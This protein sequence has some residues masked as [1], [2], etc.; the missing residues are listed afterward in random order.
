MRTF[1]FAI[2]GFTLL[3]GS[4]TDLTAQKNSAIYIL[5]VVKEELSSEPLTDVYVYALVKNDTLVI[6]TTV[7]DGKVDIILEYGKVY[8]LWYKKE[9]YASKA[10]RVD[11]RSIPKHLQDEEG[12]GLDIDIS[13]PT[14]IEGLDY[15]LL[16]EP[17][18][19]ANYSI[20][21]ENFSFDNDY[22]RKKLK[23]YLRLKNKMADFRK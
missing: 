15:S 21:D 9:G 2:L 8:D 6:D 18:G 1:F 12:Y 4:S 7:S 20:E 17:I 3:A 5:G 13:L 10:V 14:L 11:T 19:L 23:Q 16:E 22:T